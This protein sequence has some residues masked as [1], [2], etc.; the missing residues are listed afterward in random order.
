MLSVLSISCANK[1]YYAYTM[2]YIHC[3]DRAADRD[4]FFAPIR[5]VFALHCTIGERAWPNASNP[6]PV[7]GRADRF[8][9]EA[10]F[11]RLVLSFNLQ[12]AFDRSWPC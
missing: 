1:N 5:C 7:P 12:F 8:G 10:D 3:A 11:A 9:L 2:S 6:H 4:Q